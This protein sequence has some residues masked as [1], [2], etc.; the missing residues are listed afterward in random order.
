MDDKRRIG[1]D[2][3]DSTIA[4]IDIPIDG[5]ETF[6]C[7]NCQRILFVA[8]LHPASHIRII[9]KKGCGKTVDFHKPQ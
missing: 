1:D 8:R 9:C 6:K 3:W 5:A 7:P 2:V 4:D